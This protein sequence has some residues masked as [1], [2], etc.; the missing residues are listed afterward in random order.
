[1]ND[2]NISICTDV[3]VPKNG[4]LDSKTKSNDWGERL[5]FGERGGGDT[6]I[7]TGPLSMLKT[8]W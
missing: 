4:G 7:Y 1:M 5:G 3:P 2:R 6:N 8:K